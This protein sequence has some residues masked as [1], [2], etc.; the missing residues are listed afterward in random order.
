LLLLEQAELLPQGLTVNPVSLPVA[1]AEFILAVYTYL[2]RSPAKIL[3]V[4]MEDILEVLEQINIPS[5]TSQHPNWRRK[6]PI[7]LETCGTDRRA[8][9]LAAAMRQERPRTRIASKPS[10]HL[11]I[12][13]ATYRLQLNRD[14]TFVQAAQLVPYLA[15]LG[16]SHVYCSPYLKA[17]PGSNHGYDIVDHNAL[18]PEI[19]TKDE[20]E[21]FCAALHAHDMGQILDLV[22]NHMGVMG[23]DNQ[24]WLDV[25]EN[26]SASVYA[27]FFD[28]DWRPL[29]KELCG[30]VLL[31]ILGKSY[32]NTLEDGDLTLG[33]DEDCG[34]FSVWYY[35]HRLPIAPREYPRL[36]RHRLPLLEA[37]LRPDDTNLQELASLITA[38]DNLP[39]QEAISSS[40]ILE[41]RRDQELL[42]K[43]LAALIEVSL[44]IKQTVL[45][46]INDYNGS[47]GNPESFTLLHELLEAQS[48]RIANWRVASDEINYRRFFDINDLAALRIEDSHIFETTHQLALELIADGK[49]DGLRIDHPDGLYDPPQYFQ[50]L[51]DR[52]AMRSPPM[53]GEKAIY[54]VAEKILA[55]HEPL[56]E[57]WVIHG[58]TGY[59]FCNL[60]NGLF[61]DPRARV[62][63][64]R[65]YRSFTHTQPD[66]E[67]LVYHSKHQIMKHAMASELNVMA[68]QLS[69]IC[70]LRPHTRDFT[71]NNL[72]YALAEVIAC[73]PV[74]RTYVRSNQVTMLD[75]RYV[76][77]AVARAKKLTQ[78]MDISIFDFLSSVLLLDAATDKDPLY[79]DAI[80]AFAMKFQQLSSPVMA[81]GYEDTA[82][83][84]Y[85][86][87]VSL[88]EVG[89]DP[90]IFGISVNAFHAENAKRLECW[91]YSML[92]TST[93][94]N[95]RS[96]DVRARINVL[97]EISSNWHTQALRWRQL[98]KNKKLIINREEIP[99]ANDEYLIYQTLIG[100]WPFAELTATKHQTLLARMEA[101]MLKA[102]REAKQY[103]SWINPNTAYEEGLLAFIRKLLTF[104]EKNTFLSD[105]QAFHQT[106]AHWGMFNSL[107][108]TLLKLTAPG[109]PDIYQGNELWNF[110][111]VDPD[112]RRNVNYIEYQKLLNELEAHVNVPQNLLGRQVRQLLD[113]MTDGRAKLYLTWQLLQSRKRWPGVFQN[114]TY[115]PLTV[116]GPHKEHIC[117]FARHTVDMT[118]IIV[119][120]RWLSR[121]MPAA[122]NELPL[123]NTAW[124]STT[125]IKIPDLATSKQGLNVLTGEIVSVAHS[126]TA[127][128]LSAATL[129]NSFPVALLQF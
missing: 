123:G 57:D 87:L 41:R 100:I 9:A 69:R 32:G 13:L 50:R 6:L 83:Y 3:M 29:K 108:Q 76:E 112:N 56:R 28:I 113:D 36:L 17:R 70:E 61:V 66:F 91:P 93:H 22:P 11:R 89:G 73:L 37:Q 14:F 124:G 81:K 51:Q 116:T 75:R 47:I 65:T 109:V 15:Q 60:V 79:A 119:A 125:L 98:N 12:P 96:E 71:T 101:Y 20:F 40:K 44:P 78:I 74:Y 94:D 18:N 33:F 85:H 10:R 106:I 129:F 2:A 107:S 21:A 72:R 43:R 104:S 122:A 54:I 19:G 95:K 23:A 120:P 59:D 45:D 24:W 127:P 39:P 86:R 118:L 7:C 90:R 5:T 128:E 34:S 105:F 67:E 84:R 4:Q 38:L 88:N 30:K 53:E 111:L 27:A 48:W 63:L 26:G 103:T 68:G 49:V 82:F 117:A 1:T 46:T 35:H 55:N 77:W 58:T 16:I 115:L 64:E 25:L 110:S 62:T 42:K 99:S 126:N 114:G 8:L 80:T 121:L 97:S 52:A 92:S 102:V 31:P